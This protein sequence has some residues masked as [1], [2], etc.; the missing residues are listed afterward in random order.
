MRGLAKNIKYT[1]RLIQLFPVTTQILCFK[2]MLCLSLFRNTLPRRSVASVDTH[3]TMETA[4][5]GRHYAMSV[6][7]RTT[8]LS[9]V[10]A[11]GGGTVCQDIHPLQ[12][13]RNRG[14]EDHQAISNSR[15]AREEK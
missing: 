15:K 10:E 7:R 12:G 3:T 8:G 2:Q 5:H 6:A 13:H 14:K 11:P 4:Q 9:S 1:S